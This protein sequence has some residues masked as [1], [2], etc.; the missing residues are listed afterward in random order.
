ML[1]ELRRSPRSPEGR[2]EIL[3]KQAKKTVSKRSFWLVFYSGFVMVL[4]IFNRLIA[5]SGHPNFLAVK[6]S[7]VAL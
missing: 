2:S 3:N 4:A 1:A 5:I 6:P 7:D